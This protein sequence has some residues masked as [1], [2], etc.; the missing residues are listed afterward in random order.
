MVEIF[1]LTFIAL[2]LA[3]MIGR[4]FFS[5]LPCYYKSCLKQEFKQWPSP[6]RQPFISIHLP[7]CNEPPDLVIQT[8]CSLLRI[9]YE[10][11]EIIVLDN[12]T[13]ERDKWEPIKKFC[14]NKERIS[15]IHFQH[16]EGHKAGALN[17]CM[18]YMNNQSE[19]IFVLDA[20]YQVVPGILKKCATIVENKNIDLLQFPQSYRNV[21]PSSELNMEYYSYFKVFMNMANWFNC[22]LSTGTLS[23]IRCEALRDING[24]KS[25][26]ITEDAELGVRMLSHGYKPLYVNEE[27][28]CGLT[29]FDYRTFEKQ[30]KRW[31]TGNMQVLIKNIATLF[32]YTTLTIR[33]RIG[34]FFQL[35]AWIDFKIIALTVF[36]LLHFFHLSLFTITVFW[37]YFGLMVLLKL[38]IYQNTYQT[39]GLKKILGIFMINQSLV[40][41][42]GL[43][44][45][46]AFFRTNLKFEVTE[47]SKVR[48]SSNIPLI[49]FCMAITT[50]SFSADYFSSI[51]LGV[52]ATTHMLINRR[53]KAYFKREIAKK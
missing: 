2:S 32:N 21:S 31:V 12:N 15:F 34:I 40:F 46:K 39:A 53:A 52:L 11:Y 44:W 8:I 42:M 33:Q 9:R 22:V 19:Y 43:S 36:I 3:I 41:T 7:I 20:D 24:W 45:L 51:A 29:P 16:L 49:I 35:T 6:T 17:K 5:S 4:Y 37:I 28:G 27:L 47:K 14:D 13:E 25:I 18:E 1:F 50:T 48:Q 38:L 26:S 23:F 30:R 10:N